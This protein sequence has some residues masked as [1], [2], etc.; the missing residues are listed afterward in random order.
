MVKYFKKAKE[1][2]ESNY[3]IIDIGAFELV[4]S[5]ALSV[6]MTRAENLVRFIE[7]K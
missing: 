1:E 2:A 3:G 6:G 4:L 5:I 7:S